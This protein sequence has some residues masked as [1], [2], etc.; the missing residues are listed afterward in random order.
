MP[1]QPYFD[2]KGKR[3]PGV[4]TVIGGNLG[5]NKDVLMGWANREGLEGR[6]IRDKRGS[7]MQRAADIGTAAHTMIEAY[8]L[9][10]DPE[11]EAAPLMAALSEEDQ[12]KT[13]RAFGQFLRWWT[14]SKITIIGTELYGVDLDYRTGF[15]ADAL[16]IEAPMTEGAAPELVLLDWKSS[17]G[18]YADHFI[19][20]AAYVKFIEKKLAQWGITQPISAAHVV[21]VSKDHGTFKH[22]RWERDML[23]R[24]WLAFTWLRSLHEVRWELE[25]YVR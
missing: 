10:L 7:T 5:W 1:T 19:Q 23:E 8:V 24:G 4:T 15:C 12:T 20:V 13:Q 18:T 21:R 14:N 6:N 2:P 3:L 25:G 9:G 17:K 22:V 11:V 16:A